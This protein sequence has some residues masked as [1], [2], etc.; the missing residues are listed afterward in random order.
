M[1]IINVSLPNCS[2]RLS[3]I[4]ICFNE[5]ANI[6]YTINSVLNQLFSDF[7]YIIIDGGSTDGTADIVRSYESK[8][9]W[10]CSEPD[11]GI[12]DAMNKGIKRSS[13]EYI[14]F[15]NGGDI[16]ADREVLSRIFSVNRS[17]D[18]LYGDLYKESGARKYLCDM[19][20]FT[21]SPRY[22]FDHTLYHQASLTKRSL[23]ERVGYYDVSYRISGDLEFFKRAIVKHG[24][25]AEYLGFPVA[26]FNVDGIS[27]NAMYKP[28]KKKEDD[29]ARRQNYPSVDYYVFSIRSFFRDVFYVRPKRK[30]RAIMERHGE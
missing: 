25:T 17:A 26:V 21:M 29:R 10:W 15:L 22:L 14:L 6:K 7:Q 30:L 27:S 1:S 2:C 24:A 13:G 4:T 20:G 9:A 5:I 3:I 12:Y 18:I 28:I 23:F 16:L 19:S 11:E 8:L